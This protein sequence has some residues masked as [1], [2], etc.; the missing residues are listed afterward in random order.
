MT[1]S[2]ATPHP[3]V[4]TEQ[5]ASPTGSSGPPPATSQSTR[6]SVQ[7]TSHPWLIA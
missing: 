5:I 7:A 3:A 4:V 1:F 6:Y 2:H